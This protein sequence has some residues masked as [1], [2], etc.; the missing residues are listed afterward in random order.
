[1]GNVVRMARY[2]RAANVAA[3]V[4]SPL[5][6]NNGKPLQW[7]R[8]DDGV[9]GG[10][11][12]TVHSSSLD[13]RDGIHFSGRINTNGGG[14]AS[15]RAPFENGLS[16][17][18]EAL[19]IKFRGDGKKYKVLLSDGGSSGPWGGS[20]SWQADLPTRKLGPN[21][22]AQIETLRLDSFIPSFGGRSALKEE[23]RMKYTFDG[24][25]MRQ[26]GLML[27][28]RLSNGSP[29]PKETFGEG[30]FEFSLFV[31]SIETVSPNSESDI[32]DDG[33]KGTAKS[34]EL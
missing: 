31:E 23:D 20:P 16:P 12:E 15:I 2:D 9:M 28:L 6:L 10:Q 27:S 24:S 8:L 17:D 19:R 33:A 25:E 32:D 7:H 14:F 18:T 4:P 5:T 13:G 11:S 21:E 29:N 34:D 26:V 3:A 30:I 1:M 22:A